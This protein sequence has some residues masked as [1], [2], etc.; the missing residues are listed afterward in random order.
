MIYMTVWKSMSSLVVRIEAIKE[1]IGFRTFNSQD[2]HLEGT[3]RL[4]FDNHLCL[5]SSMGSHDWDYLND[6]GFE[7]FCN[8]ENGKKINKDYI[9]LETDIKSSEIIIKDCPWLKLGPDKNSSVYMKGTDPLEENWPKKIQDYPKES[10]EFLETYL[11]KSLWIA[12]EYI[13]YS[14][15][16]SEQSNVFFLE[17]LNYT[18]DQFLNLLCEN[19]EFPD[20]IKIIFYK[21]KANVNY[22]NI[23]LSKKKNDEFFLPSIKVNHNNEIL[24]FLNES[25]SKYNKQTSDKIKSEKIGLIKLINIES[26][27]YNGQ[28][29]V[30]GDNGVVQILDNS[31]KKIEEFFIPTGSSLH[32]KDGNK[33]NK[34]DL[35][36]SIN[37]YAH[38]ALA[39]K[40]G[41]AE[42]ID[43]IEE[44][45]FTDHFDDTVGLTSRNVIDHKQEPK[46][47][48]LS[49][50]I[51]I[52]K[53]NSIIETH[54]LP[55]GSLVY[56]KN[57]SQIKQGELIYSRD[58]DFD[59]SF[60]VIYDFS[61]KVGYGVSH[62]FSKKRVFQ[63][64]FLKY[65]EERQNNGMLW[66]KISYK[67]GI[68]NGSVEEFHENGTLWIKS[69]YNNGRM[70]FYEEYNSKGKREFKGNFNSK[71]PGLKEGLWK[72]FYDDFNISSE[73]NYLSGKK[74][75]KWSFY[76]KNGTLIRN[77]NW[78][79]GIK[80][81]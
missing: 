16:A 1:K 5:D 35:I 55:I 66:G 7:E 64:G 6:L 74:D 51:N 3:Y 20:Y 68:I 79:N 9:Y 2:P 42:Y 40:E 81:K 30:I 11:Y 15:K 37:P 38:M 29:K 52:V 71:K 47:Y 34:N 67:H 60:K 58:N 62:F 27:Y 13:D 80:N 22:F 33:I 70:V 73:G 21:T 46:G 12:N 78:L 50:R 32:V 17:N 61:P 45:S 14:V 72:T 28:L 41:I 26:V 63:Q 19:H 76:R 54:V 59:S 39:K 57:G 31:S 53:D 43:L 48:D 75:G 23:I 18:F 56:T 24:L 69:L 77:E 25:A 8:D 36:A 4:M 44:I 49:P 10:K 65:F